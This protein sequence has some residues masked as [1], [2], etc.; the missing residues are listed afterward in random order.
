MAYTGI[1]LVLESVLSAQRSLSWA[2]LSHLN[3]FASW[4]ELCFVAGALLRGWG[5]SPKSAEGLTFHVM[6]PWLN[7]YSSFKDT[8]CCLSCQKMYWFGFVVLCLRDNSK[9][10]VGQ[11]LALVLEIWGL[12]QKTGMIN[13]SRNGLDVCGRCHWTL[14]RINR[15]LALVI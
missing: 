11:W 13:G 7:L 14:S 15:F 10:T 2:V 5:C 9:I 3:T 1:H 8:T 4:L 6:W 12:W